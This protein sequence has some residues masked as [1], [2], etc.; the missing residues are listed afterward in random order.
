MRPREAQALEDPRARSRSRTAKAPS[1]ATVTYS[2]DNAGSGQ[3]S[4]AMTWD[5]RPST[6]ILVK[7]RKCPARSPT[8]DPISKQIAGLGE[9]GAGIA[10]GADRTGAIPPSQAPCVLRLAM[11]R[12]VV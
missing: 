2:G 3:E 5:S 4:P 7:A 1:R 12:I 11:L 9:L 10:H 6:A 8:C